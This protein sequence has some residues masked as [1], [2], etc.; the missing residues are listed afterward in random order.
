MKWIIPAILCFIIAVVFTI[1][2]F[3]D[4]GID[5]KVLK[6]SRTVANDLMFARHLALKEGKNCGVFFNISK[7]NYTLFYD[8][9]TNNIFDYGDQSIKTIS[10]D[11][12]NNGVIYS[13]LFN[14]SGAIFDNSAVVFEMYGKLFKPTSDKNSIFFY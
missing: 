3:Y 4:A 14:V 2:I 5:G 8:T 1:P 13:N 9:N 11:A 10:I 6:V 12:L 7:N